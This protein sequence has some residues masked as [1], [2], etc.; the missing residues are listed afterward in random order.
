MNCLSRRTT[1]LSFLAALL[2]LAVTPTPAVG[3]AR[4]PVE[5]ILIVHETDWYADGTSVRLSP[6]VLGATTE[7]VYAPDPA[8][9]AKAAAT[10]LS[11]RNTHHWK[12]GQNFNFKVTDYILDHK[13][14]K[15]IKK[16]LAA[17]VNK[18]RVRAAFQNRR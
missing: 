10:G 4:G 13:F 2:A 16:A 1:S 17:H 6:Y 11:V 12:L 18:P 7:G 5:S 14:D 3:D 8:R 9:T 15:L